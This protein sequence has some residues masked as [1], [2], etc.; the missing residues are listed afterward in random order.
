LFD[1]V[2][3]ELAGHLEPHIL[4]LDR[5]QKRVLVV[6]LGWTAL[7]KLDAEKTATEEALVATTKVTDKF[8]DGVPKGILREGVQAVGY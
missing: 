1:W 7:S 5:R 8:K 3:D 6:W 4:L 2:Y